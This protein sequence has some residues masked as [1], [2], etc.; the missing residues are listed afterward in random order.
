MQQAATGSAAA[1]AATA[2]GAPDITEQLQQQEAFL[3]SIW[4]A[5]PS[6]LCAPL[7]S[8]APWSSVL[9]PMAARSTMAAPPPRPLPPPPV[10]VPQLNVHHRPLTFQPRQLLVQSPHHASYG[11]SSSLPSPSSPFMQRTIAMSPILPPSSAPNLWTAETTSSSAVAVSSDLPIPRQQ[12]QQQLQQLQ[13]QEDLQQL[14]RLSVE[15]TKSNENSRFFI[16]RCPHEDDVFLSF[17][18]GVWA[19]RHLGKRIL[20]AAFHEKMSREERT[21]N[22]TEAIYLLFFP[23]NTGHFCGMAE[24][25]GP[26]QEIAKLGKWRSFG[27]WKSAFKVRWLYL[28]DINKREFAHISIPIKNGESRRCVTT[29]RDSS[30]IP[31]EQGYQMLDIIRSFKSTTSLQTD[32]E[33][34]QRRMEER[35]DRISANLHAAEDHYVYESKTSSSSVKSQHFSSSWN[36]PVQ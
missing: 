36:A 27:K 19:G 2:A 7:P 34:H 28:K 22:F 33:W 25:T 12:Q 23:D 10:T 29:L 24:L 8:S 5:Q 11:G 20:E 35:L 32:L 15:E 17:Y 18:F 4:D 3:A 1:V 21:A 13:R 26:L 30:E 6:P 16:L 14:Q 31:M 9:L